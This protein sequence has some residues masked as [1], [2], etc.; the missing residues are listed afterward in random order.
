[1]KKL[2]MEFLGTFFLVLS[3]LITGEPIAI[4]AMLMAWVYIGAFIS[5]GHYNPMVSLAMTI[6]GMLTWCHFGYYMFAQCLGA[7]AAYLMTLFLKGIVVIPSPGC[8]VSLLQ[9]GVAEVM[10][11]FV[12]ALIILVV[13]TADQFK[14]NYV[15][16]AAIG[17]TILALGTLGGPISG[18]LFNPA[19]A[20]GGFLFSLLFGAPVVPYHLAMYLVGAFLGGALAAY[21][22][23]YFYRR[24]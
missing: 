2:C 8:G 12:L 1:M 24:A 16:G 19:I 17:F 4:A 18:G 14:A 7:L 20:L 10:L 6:R 5:G 23:D 9:A 3:V 11:A 15:F 13:A 22:F 21:S